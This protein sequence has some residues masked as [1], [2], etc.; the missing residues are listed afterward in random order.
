MEDP[1]ITAQ[2]LVHRY[3]RGGRDVLA[4]HGIDLAV[5]SGEVFGMLG[6]NGAGKTTAIRILTGQLTP[7]AG[8][9]RVAGCDVRT[10]RRALHA[11][12]GVVF[13]APN[14]Y[15]GLTGRQNLRFFADLHGVDRAR[16]DVLLDRVGLGDAAD[17]RCQTYS[18]GMK[19]RVLL[20]RALLNE[21]RVLFLDEPTSGLDPASAREVRTLIAE[22]RSAGATVLVTTHQMELADAVCDRLAILHGGRV[23]TTGTPTELKRGHTAAHLVLRRATA[24]ALRLPLADPETP[25]RV[26][27]LLRTGEVTHVATEE[28]SL[29]DVFL[30]LTGSALE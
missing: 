10:D 6:P 30:A 12:I 22:L 2:A 15:D 5:P 1:A 29:E 18:K 8:T 28:P 17:R 9:A 21:P 14:L 24:N 4:L 19:Q 26:A 3:T 16:V 27:A 11:R 20:A 25:D 13:D 23:L 7:T